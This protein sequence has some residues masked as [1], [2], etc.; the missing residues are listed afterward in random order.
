MK[1]A[2]PYYGGKQS[3]AAWILDV[4][5][6]YEYKTYVEPFGGSGAILFAKEPSRVEIY[7]DV[8]S[9]VV[10]LYQVLRDERSYKQLVRFLDST[11]YSR[12]LFE[13]SKRMLAVEK[14]SPVERSGHFF[15]ALYQSYAKTIYGG[16]S[17][18]G[19]SNR[20]MSQP[21]R[22]AIKH[23]PDVHERLKNVY[24][25]HID[26]LECMKKYASDSSL[27]Y[28]DPPYVS[29]TR[30]S[31]KVYRHEYTDDQHDELVKVL[32][33]IRGHKILS[34]YESPLYQPLIDAGWVLLKKEYQCRVSKSD[35]TECLYCSPV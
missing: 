14:M 1:P 3:Q 33:A 32:L 8:Y 4:M 21:Y 5:K 23:L 17:S 35:R 10:T 15:T 20:K 2:I 24:I 7:N 29:G 31:P 12:E 22:N 34:G 18:P 11:P 16:W 26:A 30:K 9:D 27:I 6:R 28:V 19:E 13:E 25:E